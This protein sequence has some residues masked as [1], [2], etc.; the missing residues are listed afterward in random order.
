M[1]HG[2]GPR[3]VAC[4][5]EAR[6]E[7]GAG[8]RHAAALLLRSAAVLRASSRASFSPSPM[9]RAQPGVR[10]A[11][12]TAPEHI[13]QQRPRPRVASRAA[14][15]RPRLTR[16]ASHVDSANRRNTRT[17]AMAAAML[18]IAT[19]MAGGVQ[20]SH[21]MASRHGEHVRE[22]GTATPYSGRQH[23]YSAIQEEY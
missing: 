6:G 18:I 17:G 13:R 23:A 15:I 9:H 10:A 12:H 8:G 21:G 4:V 16:F 5:A 1:R 22:A 7:R 19:D 2:A 3:R 11:S 14:S 20:R